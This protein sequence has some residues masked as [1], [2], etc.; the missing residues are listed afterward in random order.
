MPTE[1]EIQKAEKPVVE[2]KAVPENLPVEEP[3][4]VVEVDQAKV[5]AERR[6]KKEAQQVAREAREEA[7]LVKRISRAGKK[8]AKRKRQA[9]R[10]AKQRRLP[11]VSMIEGISVG[12]RNVMNPPKK[13]RLTRDR[14]REK[15]D[16]RES[17][18]L[19]IACEEKE[20]SESS[21]Y[22]LDMLAKDK[23]DNK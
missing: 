5:K 20:L 6:A 19:T 7:K 2:E 8:D 17:M 14:R 16:R 18:K 21:K 12:G 11:D 9:E 15:L 10:R 13:R 1:D 3:A 22:L 23:Q 4:P